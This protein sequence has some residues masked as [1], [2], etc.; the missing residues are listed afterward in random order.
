MLPRC[1]KCF[2][3]IG[4]KLFRLPKNTCETSNQGQVNIYGGHLVDKILDGKLTLMVH[5]HLILSQC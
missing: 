2:G 1:L 5:S 4:K 3:Q